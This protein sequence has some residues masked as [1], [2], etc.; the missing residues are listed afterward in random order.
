MI[1]EFIG[2]K[3]VVLSALSSNRWLMVA[4]SRVKPAKMLMLRSLPRTSERITV[5]LSPGGV[6]VEGG[7]V[8]GAGMAG[9]AGPRLLSVIGFCWSFKAETA[10][11]AVN[12]DVIMEVLIL[13]VL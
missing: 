4:K 1:A 10:I 7:D 12:K 5:L 6:D 8:G 9:M 3:I 2:A 13:V 11:V